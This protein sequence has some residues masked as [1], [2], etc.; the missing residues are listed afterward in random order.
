MQRTFNGDQPARNVARRLLRSEIT[1]A[2]ILQEVSNVRDLV[3][4][5]LDEQRELKAEVIALREF[6]QD[7]R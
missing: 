3:D 4:A 7:E 5:L 6:V 1:V 2:D